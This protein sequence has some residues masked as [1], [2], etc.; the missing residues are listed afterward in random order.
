MYGI[1]EFGGQVSAPRGF[2]TAFSAPGVALLRGA[3]AQQGRLAERDGSILYV[4]GELYNVQDVWPASDGSGDDLVSLGELLASPDALDLLPR[5]NGS[6]FLVAV[7]PAAR[8]VRLIADRYGSRKCFYAFR[9]GRLAFFPHVHHFLG[10]GFAPRLDEDFLVQ[11]LTFKWLLGDRTLLD[12]VFLVPYGTVV[13]LRGGALTERRYWAWR[14]DESGGGP[15]D[16]DATAREMADL[17]V[18]SVAR[19]VR[20]KQRLVCP[21]SG[22]FD[23]RALLGALLECRRADDLVAVTYGTPGSLDFDLGCQVA[24]AAGVAHRTIDLSQP[25]D[26]RREFRRRAIDTDGQVEVVRTFPSEWETLLDVSPH[27]L[28]G[29]MGDCLSG[30]LLPD[31]PTAERHADEREALRAGLAMRQWVPFDITARLLRLDPAQTEERALDVVVATNGENPHRLNANYVKCWDFPNRQIKFTMEQTFL[32]RERF[33]YLLP[34]LDNAYVD[35]AMQVPLGW[36]VGQRL[37]RRMLAGRFPGL[38]RLPSARL[39]GRPLLDSWP[40][41]TWERLSWSVR[42]IVEDGTCGLIPAYRDIREKRR[43]GRVLRMD[44]EALM[45]VEGPFQAMCVEQLTRLADRGLVEA[46]AMWALW[47]EHR[48]GEANRRRALGVLVSLEF[49]AEAFLDGERPAA[50]Q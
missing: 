24:A 39:G 22:G 37:Y 50:T 11:F 25:T 18:A 34:F 46:D 10:L 43:R 44:D 32:L 30:Q 20:G 7:E 23:S 8:R 36:R 4:F 2:A 49:I 13:E 6:F 38:F 42:R 28:L 12:G 41:R 45:R 27:A 21:I 33:N 16:L 1:V 9:D 47:H 14:F 15:D 35:L 17:L 48:R 26:Y 19:R 29:F 40:S 31:H 5:L 3:E